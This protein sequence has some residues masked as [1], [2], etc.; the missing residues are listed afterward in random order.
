MNKK[1]KN[2]KLKRINHLNETIFIRSD[3]KKKMVYHR[4]LTFFG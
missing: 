4:R 3:V 2:I 1:K